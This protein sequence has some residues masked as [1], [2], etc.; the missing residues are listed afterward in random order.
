[1]LIRREGNNGALAGGQNMNSEVMCSRLIV[2]WIRDIVPL[3]QHVY[4]I[5]TLCVYVYA[6]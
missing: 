3:V 2:P 4:K 1:M 5:I 6:W